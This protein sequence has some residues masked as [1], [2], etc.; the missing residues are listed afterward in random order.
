L[1]KK[2]ILYVQTS[3]PG[4]PRKLYAPFILAQI[5]VDSN[6]EP[7][8]YFLGEGIQVVRKGIPD[9]IK[10]G[11]FDVLKNVIDRTVK[12]GVKLLVCSH[13]MKAWG[14][15]L[16]PDDFVEGTEV[17]EAS[18]LNNLVLEYDGTMWF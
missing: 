3:G 4:E 6:I 11:N 12:R 16:T 10:L 14:E 9:K 5:A 7:T 8:I 17:V 18:T 15:Y 2:K 13:S 1:D